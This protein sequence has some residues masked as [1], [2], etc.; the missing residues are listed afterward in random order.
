MYLVIVDSRSLTVAARSASRRVL[1]QAV[2]IEGEIVEP[3][4]VKA[5]DKSVRFNGRPPLADCRV[6]SEGQYQ[7]LLSVWL[8]SN[9][10]VKRIRCEGF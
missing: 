1:R 7:A 8:E 10:K 9:R 6:I 3:E 4:V 5:G 2:L